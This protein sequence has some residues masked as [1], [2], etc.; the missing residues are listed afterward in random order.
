[1]GNTRLCLMIGG[2]WDC[3]YSPLIERDVRGRNLAVKEG[4]VQ[5]S[6]FKVYESHPHKLGP[7]P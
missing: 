4:L 7:K 5:S 2:F 3:Y 6:K 1:M